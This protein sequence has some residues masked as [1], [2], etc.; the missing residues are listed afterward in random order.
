MALGPYANL[1]AANASLNETGLL[2]AAVFLSIAPCRSPNSV[3]I[4]L[5]ASSK[6][7]AVLLIVL[8]APVVAVSSV[9]DDVMFLLPKL[10]SAF[11]VVALF[12]S[13]DAT[14]CADMVV[15]VSVFAEA[16]LTAVAMA[17]VAAIDCA[18]SPVFDAFNAIVPASIAAPTI[19][20]AE[21]L[22]PF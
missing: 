14:S 8:N 18:T 2:P 17:S 9:I 19:W 5:L 22:P 3:S 7:F 4:W 21:R 15:T 11:A 20:S 1:L 6:M 10:V 13:S 12:E 16:L